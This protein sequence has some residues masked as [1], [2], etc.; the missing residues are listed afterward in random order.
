MNVLKLK[1]LS[2]QLVQ[3]HW[4]VIDMPNGK[5]FTC[6]WKQLKPMQLIELFEAGKNSEMH[7][8]LDHESNPFFVLYFKAVIR[9]PTFW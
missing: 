8:A 1:G 6:L 4:V 2:S 3:G 5:T 7:K 9:K